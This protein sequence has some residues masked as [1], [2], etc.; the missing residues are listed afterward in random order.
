MSTTTYEEELSRLR[1]LA[2][3]FSAAHPAVAPMLGQPSADPDVERLLEGW[4]F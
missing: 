1:V 3:E 2:R 4:P